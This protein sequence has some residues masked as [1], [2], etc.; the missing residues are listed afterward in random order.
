MG[1]YANL[2]NVYINI[3]VATLARLWAKRGNP[4]VKESVRE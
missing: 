1:T 4:R 2:L 3:G